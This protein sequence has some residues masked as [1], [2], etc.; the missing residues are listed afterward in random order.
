MITEPSS[1]SI[2]TRAGAKVGEPSGRVC[3]AD[4]A[5]SGSSERESP[6]PTNASSNTSK[7]TIRNL[8]D[9]SFA[10]GSGQGD[11]P[12][13]RTYR[14]QPVGREDATR[15]RDD[16]QDR[17]PTHLGLETDGSRRAQG[18]RQDFERVRYGE[19]GSLGPFD[20]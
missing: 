19:S 18:F 6:H 2:N 9:G 17:G 20:H 14:Q 1:V 3:S 5:A 13:E 8:M 10:S 15:K 7:R 11:A 4:G 16:H 12:K